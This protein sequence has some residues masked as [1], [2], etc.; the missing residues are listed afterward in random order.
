MSD[1]TENS[2]P[3]QDA[4]RLG[5]SLD[6]PPVH[7]AEQHVR[8]AEDRSD[9]SD[10]DSGLSDE[11]IADGLTA[12][13]AAADPFRGGEV[14]QVHHGVVPRPER[15]VPVGV[16]AEP[17]YGIPSAVAGMRKELTDLASHVNE[18]AH[19]HADL[20]RQQADAE[21]DRR[22]EVAQAEMGGR[23]APKAKASHDWQ[24]ADADARTI[25][26][27]RRRKYD[28]KRAEYER[29]LSTALPGHAADLATQIEPA[30]VTA[31]QACAPGSTCTVHEAAAAL[32]RWHQLRVAT[33]A[34]KQAC[35]QKV[36]RVTRRPSTPDPLALLAALPE[37]LA[38]LRATDD[39]YIVAEHLTAAADAM[40]PSKFE[41][42]RMFES[43]A[44][45][46]QELMLLERHEGFTKTRFTERLQSV[47]LDR[48]S[49]Q[50]R[51]FQR[52][53]DR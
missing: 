15:I 9:W 51:S 46:L 20:A 45:A 13:W 47:P 16:P 11:E 24:R 32:Q 25:Y 48:Y 17:P 53:L 5:I 6:G 33:A 18:A 36:P 22:R 31:E 35:G 4:Q 43:G 41:R 42:Q 12:R 49:I 44:G 38:G 8:E 37:T 40:R 19:A 3:E 30:R 52:S 34:A 39:P 1:Q 27:V 29:A 50:R 21:D 23:P 26:A 14:R 7:L 2:T 28:D 10:G